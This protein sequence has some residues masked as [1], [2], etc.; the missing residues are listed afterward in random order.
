MHHWQVRHVAGDTETKHKFSKNVVKA[1]QSVTVSILGNS[2]DGCLTCLIL[3]CKVYP[4][5]CL[6]N[7]FW[8]CFVLFLNSTIRIHCFKHQLCSSSSKLA[9]EYER[10]HFDG[11]SVG[12]IHSFFFFL[13]FNVQGG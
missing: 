6:Q 4:S 12:Y 1:G 7:K 2:E 8:F 5:P 3:V 11:S 13:F 9:R 10:S